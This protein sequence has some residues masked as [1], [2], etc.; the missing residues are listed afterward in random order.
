MKTAISTE[1]INASKS[2][3]AEI[4]RSWG[5]RRWEISFFEQYGIQKATGAGGTVQDALNNF[6][7]DQQKNAESCRE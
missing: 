5:M 2:H 6:I 3:G 1:D 7:G 4:I